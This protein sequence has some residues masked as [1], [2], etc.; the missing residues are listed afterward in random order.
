MVVVT[1]DHTFAKRAA[2]N[3]VELVAGRV[4]RSGPPATLLP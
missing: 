3:V 2:T 1:H 4:S